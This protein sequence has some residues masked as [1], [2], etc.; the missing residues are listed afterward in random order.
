MLA[1]QLRVGVLLALSACGGEQVQAWLRELG[2]R[3]GPEAN[4]VE[5][6]P[7]GVVDCPDGLARCIDGTVEVSRL[8]ERTRPCRGPERSC[9]CPWEP[10]D[11]CGRRCVAE[12]IEV[13][14]DRGRALVQLCEGDADAG[15]VQSEAA[16][17][18]AMCDE[19]QLYRCRASAIVDCLA[20]RTVL[21]C[22]RGCVADGASIDDADGPVAREAAFA[23]LCSR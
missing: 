1:G 6:Q 21:S 20:H 14:M 18:L 9:E 3:G 13:V 2:V 23:I 15:P 4:A 19:E 11:R 22:P 8:G 5:K 16:P 12:G 17:S 7:P 10:L